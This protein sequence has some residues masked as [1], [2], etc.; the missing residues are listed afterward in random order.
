MRALPLL[1]ALLGGCTAPKDSGDTAADSGAA[2]AAQMDPFRLATFNID[3]LSPRIA[4]P[5]DRR[6]RNNI[7]H[8]LLHSLIEEHQLDI[9]ALQ[10]IEGQGAL[11]VLRFGDPWDSV[12]GEQG[13][14]QNL[15]VLYRSDRFTLEDVREVQLPG[16]EWP[17]RFPLVA[18]VRHLDGLTFTLVVVH[19]NAYAGAADSAYRYNQ[20]K[21]LRE[22]LDQDLPDEVAPQ[23]ARSVVVAGDFN[24]DFTPLNSAYP[25]LETLE[26]GD[27]W[28]FATRQAEAPTNIGYDST[29]DHIVLSAD[30]VPRWTERDAAKGCHVIQH[31]TLEP[32]SDYGGGYG[33]DQNISSHRPVWIALDAA[34]P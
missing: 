31:D 33:N 1:A 32:W 30:M 16:T 10:E 3:W 5:D 21:R 9:V 6:P 14:S 18:T 19:H 20:A 34:L 11:D 17:D 29:I 2:P 25:S 24:D 7:D 12:V 8:Q 15:A 22:Y 26:T 23:L 4:D 27:K 13:W 28:R